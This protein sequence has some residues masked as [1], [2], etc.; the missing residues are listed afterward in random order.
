MKFILTRHTTT[1]WN[2]AGRIQGQIDIPL[3]PQG[4][5]EATELAKKLSGLGIHSI[6]SSD[7]KRASETA[8]FFDTI[9]T[10]GSC[11]DTRNQGA[12]RGATYAS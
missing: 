9:T 11:V 7:L 5:D 10:L 1:E 3:A 4:K 2:L 6:V 8:R 12:I